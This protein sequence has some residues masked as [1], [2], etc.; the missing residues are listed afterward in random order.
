MK[1]MVCKAYGPP[2]V[3]QLAEVPKPIPTNDEVLIRI[4]A[5]AVTMSDI[6]I[7]SSD[8]PLRMRI[9]MRLMLGITRPRRPI[10]GEV[11]A[12]EVEAVGRNI[13]RFSVGDKVCGVTG[14]S[15]GA[16]AEYKCMRE[17]DSNQGCLARMARNISF[18][19]GTMAAYGGALALQ[20]LDRSFC[21]PGRKVL[22]YGASGT[23][24]TTA[25]QL[26]RHWGA[27]V[28]AVCG[29]T[30]AALVRSLGASEVLDYTGS[31]A[32]GPAQRFDFVLD[33]VGKAKTSPLKDACK[34]ALKPSGKYASIDDASLELVAARLESLMGLI[35]A[36]HVHPVLDR[37]YPFEQ[38]PEAH[39]YVARGHKAGG[40]AITV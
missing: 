23:T 35:E 13:R 17:T 6:F 25:V 9:P 30:H 8:L 3:L 34:R 38:L 40:V 10:I 19:E 11:L 21:G 31:D 24:G 14:F 18:E 2:E 12:G 5:T 15:L 26:A 1:A 28:T 20:F 22:V 7:R 32:L 16:Y 29:P 4:R 39:A 33:A 27:S 36:G 37:C